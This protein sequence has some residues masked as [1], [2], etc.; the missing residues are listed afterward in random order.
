[1]TTPKVSELREKTSATGFYMPLKSLLTWGTSIFMFM[2]FLGLLVSY[3]LVSSRESSLYN[4]LQNR[5]EIMTQDRSELIQ[6]WAINL[7]KTGSHIA[8][9]DVIRLFASESDMALQDNNVEVSNSIRQQAKYFQITMDEYVKQNNLANAYIAGQG[10]EVFLKS[11]AAAGLTSA[12]K[13]YVDHVIDT[14]KTFFSPFTVEDGEIITVVAR[15]IFALDVVSS[16]PKTVATLVSSF[17]VTDNILHFLKEGPLNKAGEKTHI[18]Q[19]NFGVM[20]SIALANKI[21]TLYSLKSNKIENILVGKRTREEFGF[22][23]S[24]VGDKNTFAAT[25]YVYGTPFVVLQEY[26]EKAALLP[27][28]QYSASVHSLMLLVIFVLSFSVLLMLNYVVSSRNRHR[29]NHQQQVL[30]ALVKSVEIRDP[31]L[32]GHHARVAKISLDIANQMRLSIPERSTLYY[33]AMLSGI[34]KIFVPRRILTKPGKLTATETAT[35]RQHIN[36]AMDVL[37]DMEF[38]FPIA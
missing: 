9:A 18:L 19:D 14:G 38:E 32:S 27:I 23:K 16:S 7:Q 24:M 28:K 5:I 6:S 11:S 21:P 34:G 1:M 2:L 8:N 15:P 33:A 13:K 4:G 17:V 12:Y 22:S 10:G 29:V 35:L 37:G 20:Q 25:R 31:Y 3:F 36:Y 30:N 26:E